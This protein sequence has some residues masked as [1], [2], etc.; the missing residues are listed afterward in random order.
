MLTARQY[1]RPRDLLQ[2][3]RCLISTVRV[4]AGNYD[5]PEVSVCPAM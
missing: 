1:M 2:L 3:F 5:V 4:G